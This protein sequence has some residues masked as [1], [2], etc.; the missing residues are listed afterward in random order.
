MVAGR[1]SSF[2]NTERVHRHQLVRLR[3]AIYPKKHI[4]TAQR[5]RPFAVLS[6]HSPAALCVVQQLVGRYVFCVSSLMFGSLQP[7][8]DSNRGSPITFLLETDGWSGINC[9]V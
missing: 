3:C 9:S 7:L 1:W 4:Y 6:N 5:A 8:K 2:F